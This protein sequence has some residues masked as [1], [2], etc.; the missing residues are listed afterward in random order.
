MC[1]QHRPER[2]AGQHLVDAL[3]TRLAG[4]RL[5]VEVDALGVAVAP[6]KEAQVATAL[7]DDQSFVLGRQQ[8]S[9]KEG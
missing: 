8:G 5:D 7:Q 6:E 9:A 4:D 3:S 2:W 1:R